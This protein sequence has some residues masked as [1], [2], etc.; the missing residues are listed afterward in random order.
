M[1]GIQDCLKSEYAP[2]ANPLTGIEKKCSKCGEIKPIDLFQV[3]KRK[4]SGKG[5]WCK[6]CLNAASRKWGKE[7]SEHCLVVKLKWREKN[8][9]RYDTKLK[10]WSSA[11]LE[12][13]RVSLKNYRDRHPE[14]IIKDKARQEIRWMIARGETER[15]DN[16]SKCGKKCKTVGH[17]PDYNKP[18]E[19]E[20]LCPRCHTITHCGSPILKVLA[21]QREVEV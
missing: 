14:N 5:S 2:N 16:C 19:V 13:R 10:E 15:A 21:A 4:V 6:E 18:R 9:A 8:R 12:R 1:N 20:W 11:N 7:N 17:H 3:D